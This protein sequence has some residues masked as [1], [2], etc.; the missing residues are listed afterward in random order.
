MADRIE[1][2]CIVTRCKSVD[3]LVQAFEPFVD[4]ETCF[5][6]NKR[7]RPVGTEIAFSI[8]LAD[9]ASVLRGA[10]RAGRCTRGSCRARPVTRPRRCRS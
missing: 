3:E 5:I 4:G 1:A 7:G 10:R 2:L 8:R 9:N 6:P